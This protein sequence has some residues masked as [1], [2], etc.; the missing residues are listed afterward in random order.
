MWTGTHN[1]FNYAD[2][3]ETHVVFETTQ[4][5]K[6]NITEQLNLGARILEVLSGAAPRLWR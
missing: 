3:P 5:Q 6:Y 1:S 2:G 4:N